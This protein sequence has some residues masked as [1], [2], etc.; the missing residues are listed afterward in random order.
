VFH[1]WC[2]ICDQAFDIADANEVIT[3]EIE[4]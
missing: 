2:S 1:C 4:H 3:E